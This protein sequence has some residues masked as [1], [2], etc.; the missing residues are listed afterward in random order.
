MKN[1]YKIMQ[2]LFT[3][4]IVFAA[5]ASAELYERAPDVLPGTLP[6]MRSTSYWIAR[7]KNP[8]EV[9]LPVDRIMKMNEFYEKKMRL[10][11]PFKNVDS[12][13][14]SILY[15]L[16]ARKKPLE[17]P[18]RV[19]SI[20]DIHSLTPHEIS[21][22]VKE[23][24]RKEIKYLRSIPF[25]N[26]YA[27][28]Y[29][30]E[31]IDA[32][33][34]E[35]GLDLVPDKPAV[36]DAITVRHTRIRIVPSFYPLHMGLKENKTI[37]NWDMWNLGIIKIGRPVTVIHSSRTGA[38]LFVLSDE[39][40]GW[41]NAEDVAFGN[42]RTINNFTESTDFIVCTGDRIPFYTNEKCTYV[43][44]WLRMGDCAPVAEKSNSRVI[45]VPLRK[46]D[47]QFVV[48]K[49]WLSEDADVNIGWLSYTRR[50]IVETAFKL[51]DNPYDWTGAWFGRNHE[52][53]YRDIFACFGFKLPYQSEL[54][55]HFGT[56]EEVLTP[57][58]GE[59]KSNKEIL[60]HEPFVTI[61][62]SWE[63][64]QLLLGDDNGVPI[65]FDQHGYDYESEDGTLLSIKR[66]CI[67]DTRQPWYFYDHEITFLELK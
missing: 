61:I 4:I 41:V 42:R 24:I 50:N 7:M 31:E 39:G 43:S 17:R 57:D 44:G 10:A 26:M 3:V 46:S 65:V 52:T 2:G 27:I 53:T 30:P 29:S 1:R 20:P 36:L 38:F 23:T 25:G 67:G 34:R 51:L 63:H 35:M 45:F 14:K 22:T 33:E 47:G 40:Y 37:R 16:D 28:E 66:C 58:M 6:E 13:R 62:V 12:E 59:E 21:N 56:N 11:D 64:G 18:G 5:T 54:F 49:A 9:I 60:K 32:F 48:E 15:P 8:D 19:L 55:T